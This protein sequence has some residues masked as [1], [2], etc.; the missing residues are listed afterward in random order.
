MTLKNTLPLAKQSINKHRQCITLN[1]AHAGF[2]A[3]QCPKMKAFFF[4]L[5]QSSILNFQALE[6]PF[7][8]FNH[9]GRKQMCCLFYGFN[10]NFKGSTIMAQTHN[11][12]WRLTE[13]I[14]RPAG[15][16]IS[17]GE[18]K[19]LQSIIQTDLTVSYKWKFA[20]LHGQSRLIDPLWKI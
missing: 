10:I 6:H 4:S 11:V 8:D 17:S 14:R 18:N 7:H 3:T 2:P 15:C 20:L 12:C 5:L 13:E 19:K 16:V 9:H 1:T